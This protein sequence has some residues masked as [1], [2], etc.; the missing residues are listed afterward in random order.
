LISLDLGGNYLTGSIAEDFFATDC[1]LNF[2]LIQGSSL[3]GTFPSSIAS[4]PNIIKILAGGNKFTSLPDSIGRLNSLTTLD[5]SENDLTKIPP[6]EIWSNMTSLAT[7]GLANNRK[8][9]G[10]LHQAWF[11]GSMIDLDASFCRFHG[12]VPAINTTTLSWLRLSGNILDGTITAPF[13]VRNLRGLFLD[14]NGLHGPIPNEFGLETAELRWTSMEN[15]NVSFNRLTGNISSSFH[16][17][18]TLN[19]I[20]LNNNGFHGPLPNFS[21]LTLVKKFDGSTNFFDICAAD[22][23]FSSASELFESA[24]NVANNIYPGACHCTSFVLGR[25]RA[26]IDCPAPGFIPVPVA[27]GE[28]PT[29][30]RPPSLVP[31]SEGTPVAPT[32]INTPTGNAQGRSLNVLLILSLVASL[33]LFVLF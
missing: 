20:Y 18:T 7:L 1:S 8:L 27:I 9:N 17:M 33:G 28:A 2:F 30:I 3:S 19:E 6:N 21:R 26:D 22:P 14:Q 31:V 11:S 16:F 4:C 10:T 32:P 24:C 13:K 12:D 23:M 5:F 25:C 29:P 15:F